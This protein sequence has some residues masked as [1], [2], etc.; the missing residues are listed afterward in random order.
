MNDEPRHPGAQTM[1]AFFDGTLPAAEVATVASHLRECSECRTVVGET[2]RFEREEQAHARRSPLI[3][4]AWWLAAAAILAV[5][6]IGVPL[7]R[8]QLTRTSDPIARL[9]EA[10]PRG[11]RLV[12]PRLAGFR[13]ARLQSS[14]R[15]TAAADPA[16]LKLAGAAGGGVEEK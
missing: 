12:Q 7:L 1:A 13:W 14:A 9:I 11:H 16:D 5:A 15:G 10:A 6:V 4:R 3:S 2:A 8:V